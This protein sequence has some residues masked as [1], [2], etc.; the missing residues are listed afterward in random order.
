M[1]AGAVVNVDGWVGGTPQ[2]MKSIGSVTPPVR[3]SPA[4]EP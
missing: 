4:V 3:Q 1:S 2:P